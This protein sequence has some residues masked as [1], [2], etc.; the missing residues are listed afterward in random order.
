MHDD[1]TVYESQAG[2]ISMLDGL[3]DDDDDGDGRD[4]VVGRLSS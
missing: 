2:D 3:G 1:S 4:S